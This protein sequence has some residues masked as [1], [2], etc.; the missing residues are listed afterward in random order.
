MHVARYLIAAVALVV[1]ATANAETRHTRQP[2]T[3]RVQKAEM[4]KKHGCDSPPVEVVAGTESATIALA[5]CDGTPVPAAVDELSILARPAS[6][7]KPK[8]GLGSSGRAHG[9]EV[10][11]GIRR[12]DSRLVERL[13]RVVNHF[14]KAGQTSRVVLVSGYRPRS[15]GSYHSVGRALDFRVDGVSNEAV[16]E[17]CKTLPDTGC[18]YYPNSVFVHMDVRPSGAGHV[19]WVDVSRPGEEPKYVSRWPVSP[20]DQL[21]SLPDGTRGRDD[22]ASEALSD[23]K[24]SHPYFF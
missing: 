23:N 4:P 20:F 14:R 9:A 7:P 15:T 3:A 10:T 24:V 18:G 8:Q 22:T 17:F 11:P 21:P 13:D 2:R 5:K 6:A 16:L 1:P 19:A 12:L